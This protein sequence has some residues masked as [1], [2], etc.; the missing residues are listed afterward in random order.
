MSAASVPSASRQSGLDPLRPPLPLD[1]MI[2][3]EEWQC[4]CRGH[5][6]RLSVEQG[7]WLL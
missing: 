4:T 7:L 1:F 3:A 5:K 2:A 6:V